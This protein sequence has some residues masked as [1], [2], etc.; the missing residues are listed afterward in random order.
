M[1]TVIFSVTAIICYIA[2]VVTYKP[3]ATYKNGMLFAITLP[4]HA[5]EHEEIQSIRARFNKQFK[6]ASLWMAVCYIPFVLLHYLMSYQ[7]IYFFVWITVFFFVM[8]IPFRRAFRDTL[9]LKREHDWFVGMKRVIQSDLRVAHLKNQQSASL[10]LFTIPFAMAIGT[11]LWAI[12][13][14][15]EFIG[16]AFVGLIITSLFLII[17]LLMRGSKGK[18]YSENSEVNVALN[19]ARRRSISYLWL[20]MAIVENIHVIFIYLWLLNDN[21]DMTG[22][23]LIILLLF[24]V[25]PI[26]LIY[27]TYRNIGALE[28]EVLAQDGKVIYTDDDEYWANG[29]TYHNPNDRSILVPKRIGIGETINTGTVVGKFSMWGTVGLTA[30]LIV[31]VSFMLIRSELTSP[32]LTV[33]ADHKIEIDYPMYSFDFNLTDIEEITLVNEVPSGMKS[34]GEATSDYARGHFKL[35]EIGKTR[36][37]IFKNNPPYIRIKLD[38]VYIFYNEK[39]PLLTKELFDQ[40]KS[41]SE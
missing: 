24:T 2:L 41:Y 1:L 12:A 28:Q 5:M 31:G 27:Y 39:D 26:G 29:F 6:K 4:S 15:I 22:V 19:Q 3:Q 21:E 14:D 8:V 38:D 18:V 17:S 37:Y 13:E 35:K 40:L 9:A 30:V 20:S 36:L 16:V 25:V 7:F 10:W 34:N 32:V 23:W 11:M 33:T